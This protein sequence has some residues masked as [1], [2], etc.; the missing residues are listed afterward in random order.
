MIGSSRISICLVAAIVLIPLAGCGG[1]GDK[2]NSVE[3][4]VDGTF[5]G[6]VAGTKAFVAVV[7]A[8]VVGKQDKR[9][10][11]VYVTDG[12]RLSEWFAGS[13]ASNSFTA[14]SDDR[15]AEIKGKLSGKAVTGTLK[16]PGGKTVDYQANT[17][18]GAA[19]LYDLTVSRDG[20]LSG[21]SA[22]GIGLKG[23]APLERGVGTLKLA[24][25]KRHKFD[26]TGDAAAGAS[27]KS[28]Q[29]RLIVLGDGELSGAGKRR[30]VKGSGDPAFLIRSVP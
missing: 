7:A 15:D 27:L 26:L 20:E 4:M 10:V 22:A 9:D 30:S 18:T 14:S 3:K 16:L 23:E 24:D 25:G 17:A 28:G 21:A 13:G 29:V 8:P 19:G 5:V 6:K 2:G 1:D 11:S 12:K